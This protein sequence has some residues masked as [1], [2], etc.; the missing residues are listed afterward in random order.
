[1]PTLHHDYETRSVLDIEEVGAWRYSQHASTDVWGCAFAVDDGPVEWWSPGE[2]IPEPFILAPR[3]PA[4]LTCAYNDT[5]ERL[6]TQHIT[7]P[8]YGFP[9]VPIERRRC[10]QASSLALALPGRLDKVAKALG[11]EA[12]KDAAGHRTMLQMARP[13]KPRE[14]EDPNGIYWIDDPEKYEA[15]KAYSKIDVEVERALYHR[16]GLLPEDEQELWRLDSIINDRGIYLDGDLIEAAIG[17]CEQVKPAL[18]AELASLT[19]G[20]VVSLDQHI[21]LK[22]WLNTN[23]CPI[24]DVQSETIVAGRR[25][26]RPRRCGGGRGA[27]ADCRGSLRRREPGHRMGLWRDLEARAVGEV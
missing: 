21:K 11:L 24:N 26:C 1:M 4:W 3:D 22:A 18:R 7:G 20:L 25:Q 15:L 17:V 6:I 2:P 9:L 5:F 14:G 12:Q 13:R 19:G 16:I 23:G 10:L 27:G 8:R